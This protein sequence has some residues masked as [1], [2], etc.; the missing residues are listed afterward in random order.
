MPRDGKKLLVIID[1]LDEFAE[2]LLSLIANESD[3]GCSRLIA[4]IE[5][6]KKNYNKPIESWLKGWFYQYTRVRGPDVDQAI[7]GM[8]AFPD[9]FTRLQEFKSLVAKGEWN[10]GSFNYCLFVE[11][12][13]AIPGYKP[14]DDELIQPIIVRLKDLISIRIDGFMYQYKANQKLME[15]RDQ[16]RLLTHQ[17]SQKSIETVL[18]TH[19]LEGAQSA[20][21][22]QPGKI[23]FSLLMKNNLWELSWIDW[24]GKAYVLQP[25]EELI[26][27]LF[28]HEIKDVEHLN[29]VQLKPLKRECLKAREA[30]LEKIHVLINL[31]NPDTL[32]ELSVNDLLEK[33]ICST[34]VIRGEPNQYSLCWIN[35][36]S[37][38]KSIP[39]E[40][41][42]ELKKWLDTLNPIKEEHLVQLKTFLLHVNTTRSLG[43]DDFKSKLTNCLSRSPGKISA[44]KVNDTKRLD[45]SLFSELER[46]FGKRI[47][48]I[49]PLID[50]TDRSEEKPEKDLPGRLK[51]ESYAVSNLFGHRT[52][53][54]I[55]SNIDPSLLKDN[56]PNDFS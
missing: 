32:E 1:N 52:K 42:P 36:L 37:K 22:T 40:D 47:D 4:M 30:F 11:L 10:Q 50:E 24:T 23:V 12:I 31:K 51:I 16:E 44:P 26:K 9:A 34:F 28:D 6:A 29:P 17:S 45:L 13:K 3:E 20:V 53:S 5:A 21:K 38:N 15:S 56:A 55:D 19:D 43:M 27:F 2:K 54:A 33:G 35:T 46:C 7:K 39:L 14:I 8:A 41:Y 18:I 48:K 25:G 49:E